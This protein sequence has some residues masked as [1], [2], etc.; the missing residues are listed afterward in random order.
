[1]KRLQ[2]YRLSKFKLGHAYLNTY[3]ARGDR[4]HQKLVR[5]LICFSLELSEF[6][7]TH[8]KVSIFAAGGKIVFNKEFV[9]LQQAVKS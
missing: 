4:S 5:K 6:F 2:R 1:M 8:L 3:K 9:N 7:L